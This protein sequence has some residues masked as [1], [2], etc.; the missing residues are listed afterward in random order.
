MSLIKRTV[1]MASVLSFLF[2]GC[3]RYANE[4]ELQTLNDTRNA[5]KKAESKLA[6]LKEERRSLEDKLAEKE[7]SLKE[8][9]EEKVVVEGRINESNN[10]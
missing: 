9:K 1:L 8:V 6:E 7:T 3:T 4:D 5:S 2:V 10:Q